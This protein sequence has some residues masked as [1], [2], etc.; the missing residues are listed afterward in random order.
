MRFLGFDIKRRKKS[1]LLEVD[2]F[3]KTVEY[4]NNLCEGYIKLLKDGVELN[5]ESMA[6]LLDM[7]EF[8]VHLSIAD[9][10]HYLIDTV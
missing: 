5:P 9:I 6:T 2:V 8:V 1:D 7:I 3:K 4:I 10:Q